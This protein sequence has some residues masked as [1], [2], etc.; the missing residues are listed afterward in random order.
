MR[1]IVF[2]SR[3]ETRV[4]QVQ[5]STKGTWNSITTQ[6]ERRGRTIITTEQ[7]DSAED[8][9]RNHGQSGKGNR[10]SQKC[11]RWGDTTEGETTLVN[12]DDGDS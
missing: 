10:D 9:T 1:G 12:G 2:Q 4:E 8:D 5:H 3:K 11:L 6:E 7:G